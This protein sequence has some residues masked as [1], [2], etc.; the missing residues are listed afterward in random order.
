MAER[1]D[2]SGVATGLAWTSAGGD[3]LFIEATMMPGTGKL[4][5]TGKLG[6]VMQE[7]AQTALSYVRSKATVLGI[8]KEVF[9]DSDIHVHVP[10]GA[11][12]KDGPSAGVTIMTALVSLLTG[13]KVRAVVAMTGE[14]TLQGKVLPVGGIKEKV[15]TA[16]RAGVGLVVLPARNEKDLV[17]IPE[18]NREKIQFVFAHHAEDVLRA[19][20]VEPPESLF[21][22]SMKNSSN[23]TQP[24]HMST[25]T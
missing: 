21:Q 9:K 11:I 24:Q 15:L 18:Q 3:I 13:I 8:K 12:P 25:S 23:E 22:N 1:T 7:S 4:I 17:E 14:I 10:A 20:L 19:V 6:D 5:M 2:I 16:Q